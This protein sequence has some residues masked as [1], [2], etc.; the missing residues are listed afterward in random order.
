MYLFNIYFILKQYYHN[1]KN[2]IKNKSKIK[3]LLEIII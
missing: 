3:Y 1:K 2:K